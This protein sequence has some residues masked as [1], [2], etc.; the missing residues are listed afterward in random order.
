MTT[1]QVA[2]NLIKYDVLRGNSFDTIKRSQHG[3]FCKESGAMIG[4]YYKGK[5]LSDKIIV[6]RVNGKDI[7]P[8]IF[9]LKEIFNESQKE[10]QTLI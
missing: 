4:G 5:K 8:E 1:K 7:E 3:A 2:I 6:N 9:N 10:Q